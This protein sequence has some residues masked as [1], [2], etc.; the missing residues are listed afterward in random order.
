MKPF[1]LKQNDTLP[2]LIIHVKT[3]GNLGEVIAFDLDGVTGTTFS[4]IDNCGNLK[5]SKSDATILCSS[6]GT[7]QYSWEVMDT[8]ESGKFIGEFELS[9]SGSG[10][11]SVPQMGG[12]DIEI[13]KDINPY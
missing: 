11:L 7:L 10:K 9:Y 5:V 4:M 13:L 6:G 1:I 8:D 12:I 3:R 2:A